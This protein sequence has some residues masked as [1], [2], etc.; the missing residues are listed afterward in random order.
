MQ[1]AIYQKATN[2]KQI[3]WYIKTPTKTK[4]AEYI[5]MSLDDYVEPY[6]I[7]KHIIKVMGNYLKTVDTPE[8]VKNSLVPNPD[9]WIWKEP[10]VLEA[11]KE[12]WGY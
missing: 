3:L 4:D 9:N 8:D 2:A 1:Q 10:T 5:A 7:C 12:V 11:R 6:N